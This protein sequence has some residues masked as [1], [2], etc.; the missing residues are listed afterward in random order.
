MQKPKKPSTAGAVVGW[1]R[2]LKGTAR[3][4]PENCSGGPGKPMQEKVDQEIDIALAQCFRI[5]VLA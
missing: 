1:K 4:R 2:W 3:A 5:F